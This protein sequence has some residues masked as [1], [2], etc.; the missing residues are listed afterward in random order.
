MRTPAYQLTLNGQNITDRLSG[1]LLSLTLTDRRGLEA[2][3]LDLELEDHDGL[4]ALPPTGAV[5]SLSLGWRGAL[6]DRG[7]Y[8]V[9]EIG[10][11]GAPDTLSIRARSADFRGPLAAKRSQSW[12]S[13][14]LGAI[15]GEIAARNGLTPAISAALAARLIEHLD[16]TNESDAHLLSRLAE[17]NDAVATAKAG[18]LLVT[19]KGG[20][21]SVSGQPLPTLLLTR[22][23]GDNHRYTLTDRDTY[24]GVIAYWQDTDLGKRAEVVAGSAGESDNPKRLRPT[25]ATRADAVRAAE[26][27]WQRV[28]R[29]EASLEFALFEGRADVF[30]ELPLRLT[31]IKTELDVLTWVITE[32]RHQLDSSGYRTNIKA[33]LAN[34]PAD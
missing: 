18:K 20:G 9:D 25:Y 12:D 23:D 26:S 28:Q 32:V 1:R 33:E 8:T 22:A 34:P 31:G 13:T 27:E 14:T 5:L 2:D 6:I 30:P 16:Q 24:T 11:Q 7:Q 17:D 15:V 19:P 21:A 29:G 4:L 10:H 3:Q